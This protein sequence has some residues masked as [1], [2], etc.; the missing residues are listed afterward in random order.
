M[1]TGII[2]ELGKVKAL[3]RRGRL[4]RLGIE[5]EKITQD[6]KIG[7]SI[8]VNGVCLTLVAVENNL[9]SFD[10]LNETVQRSN[11]GGLRTLE[12]VNLERALKVGDRLSGHFVNG[13]IDCM[14][15]IRK[16]TYKDNNLCYEI[17]F[18]SEFS[19]YAVEKGS[20]AV[21]GISLTISQ[22]RGGSFSVNVIPHTLVNTTLKFKGPSSK[23]NLEFDILLKR[24]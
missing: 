7:D 12:N 2:E 13:H 4:F 15:I 11:I 6:I 3:E 22:I 20:I 18:P 21:D 23:V 14:G 24:K 10:V 8:S 9:I 19:S 5:A 17:S 1:F 16:K